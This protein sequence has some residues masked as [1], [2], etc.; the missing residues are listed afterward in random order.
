MPTQPNGTKC[1]VELLSIQGTPHFR[2]PLSSSQ[3][4]SEMNFFFALFAKIST[5][6]V[7]MLQ[8]FVTSI[9]CLKENT[10]IKFGAN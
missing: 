10:S 7:C 6:Q 9:E 5:T 3:D 1:T 2:N 4:T 8:K